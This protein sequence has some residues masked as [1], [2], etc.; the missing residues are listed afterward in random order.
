MKHLKLIGGL[1]PLTLFWPESPLPFSLHLP[2]SL[3]SLLHHPPSIHPLLFPSA[4]PPL[5]TSLL[6]G[7]PLT[8][9]LRPK[10]KTGQWERRPGATWPRAPASVGTCVVWRR[11][12]AASRTQ[13]W[14]W[15]EPLTRNGAPA[16]APRWRRSW[17]WAERAAAPRS[18]ARQVGVQ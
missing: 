1:N 18:S 7:P 2:N 11:P 10:W 17:G 9:N 14:A 15:W 13:P 6:H 12:T 8:V 3:L 16:S 4:A 5:F